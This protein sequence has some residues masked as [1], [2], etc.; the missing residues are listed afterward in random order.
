MRFQENEQRFAI[1][2]GN[3]R[4]RRLPIEIFTSSIDF[5]RALSGG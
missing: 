3:G 4:V 5:R 2:A 1:P